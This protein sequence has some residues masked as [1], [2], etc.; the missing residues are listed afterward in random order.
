MGHL[1]LGPM[2]RYVSADSATVWV[3]TDEPGVVEILERRQRTFT[4]HGHHYALVVI[5]GL[6]PGSTT[7]YE[8]RVNG[9]LC[10]PPLGSTFPASCIRTVAPDEPLEIL[11][12]SCRAALPHTPP[13]TSD[14]DTDRHG[15]GVDALHAVALRLMTQDRSTWPHLLLFI[16]DQIYADDSSPQAADRIGHRLGPDQPPAQIVANFEEYTWLYHESWTSEPERWLMSTIPSAMIFDD[17]D[18]IDDWNISI[19]WV[20]DIRSKRWWSEHVIGG[21]VSYWIYQHLGNLSPARIREEGLLDRLLE[22]DDGT[23][24]LWDWAL[25]SEEFTPLP[26]GYQF[27]FERH[28]GTVHLVVIDSRNGRELEPHRRLMV[29]DAEWEWL[30]DRALETTEHLL[31][32]SSLPVFLPGGVHCIQQWNEPIADGQ[33]GRAPARIAERIRRGLDLEGWPAFNRS[34]RA[35]ERLLIDVATPTSDHASPPATITVLGGDIHFAYIAEIALPPSCVSRVRQVVSSPIRHTLRAR[36]AR[37]MRLA[38]GRAGWRIGAWLM[39]IVGRRASALSW[40]MTHGPVFH[41]NIGVFATRD[42]DA[43]VIIEAAG[44][45]AD[46]HEQL[47][48]AFRS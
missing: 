19:S 9:T 15:K 3:E 37:V 33:F 36:E 41:N 22:C 10:W 35:F 21:L 23:P 30:R 2:L 5:E 18:M 46:G 43:S 24:V 14:P 45:D 20:R 6:T 29:G 48:V 39:R 7:E 8:V 27:S 26:G 12:G 13:F 31:L 1:R 4:V 16:G 44:L 38:S 17:H 40:H 11:F 34:F 25:E 42:E 47:M 32:V 28:L